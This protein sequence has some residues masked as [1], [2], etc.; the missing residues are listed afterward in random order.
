MA[1]GDASGL[2]KVWNYQRHLIRE[3]LFTD[4]ISTLS[5]LNARG[6]LIIG[7]KGKLSR[8]YAKDYLPDPELYK[9]P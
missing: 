1:T 9:P 4:P 3:I 7:H 8:I 6:D 2:I 5:F